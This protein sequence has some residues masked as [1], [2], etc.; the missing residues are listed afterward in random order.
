[1][2]GLERKRGGNGSWPPFAAEHRLSTKHGFFSSPLLREADREEVAEIAGAIVELM[3][4]W[5]PS[6]ALAVEGLACKLW[7]Q[8]RAYADLTANGLVRED[9]KPAPVLHHL[10]AVE[11][12]IARDLEALGLTPRAAA[13]LGLDVASTRRQLSLIELHEQAAAERA[14]DD[15]GGEAA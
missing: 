15:G 13:A 1:V 11:N 3:P 12:A 2:G 9:G 10:V 5:H 4:S 14:E 7:R 8:R 6:F